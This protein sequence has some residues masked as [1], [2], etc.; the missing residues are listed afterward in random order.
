MREELVQFRGALNRLNQMA[1]K[2]EVSSELS[3]SMGER[4]E[5]LAER[6]RNLSAAVDTLLQRTANLETSVEG[7]GTSLVTLE[8]SQGLPKVMQPPMK[9]RCTRF[10]SW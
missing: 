8:N 4:H 6:H 5:N 3:R 9:K 1:A 2:F 7:L 10:E